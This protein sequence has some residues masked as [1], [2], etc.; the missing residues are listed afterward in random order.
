ML[1]F[2]PIVP[3]QKLTNRCTALV[4]FDWTGGDAGRK[5]ERRKCH[6]Y[7]KVPLQSILVRQTVARVIIESTSNPLVP[8]GPNPCPPHTHRRVIG[9][10]ETMSHVFVRLT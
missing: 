1:I 2:H 9:R 4:S 6:T 5:G 3:P 8:H 10:L 7:P